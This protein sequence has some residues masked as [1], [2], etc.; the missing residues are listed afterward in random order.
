MTTSVSV[1]RHGRVLRCVISAADRSST[2]DGERMLQAVA[3]MRDP[4]PD[5]G[6]I[7]LAGD[8]ANFCT[9]GNVGAFAAAGDGGGRPG[10]GD[11]GAVVKAMAGEFHGFARAM[12]GCP[13]PVIAAVHGWA[14]GAGMSI[15]CLADIVVAGT[16]ARFRPSYPGI[17]FSPDGGMSWTL[18]RLVGA[19]R[20]RHILLTDQV[21]GAAQA[22]A[23]GLVAVVVPDDQV[24]AEAGRLAG[25]LAD[26]PTAAL[27]RIKRLIRDGESRDLDRSLDAEAIEIAAS[28]AGAEGREGVRAFREKRPARFHGD[29]GT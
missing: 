2:L 17:G 18:P 19:A 13:V 29:Q 7:L 8:G 15:V 12:T 1:Q 9:G 5:T 4:G 14:A 28:A 16:S 22:L 20:A 3:V 10:G 21:L 27:G 6:A 26:G 24:A 25:R 11:V 23:L